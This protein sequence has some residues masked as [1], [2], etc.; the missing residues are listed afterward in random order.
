M[1]T[2]TNTTNGEFN[3]TLAQKLSTCNARLG[4]DQSVH[5]VISSW[6]G[7][8]ERWHMCQPMTGQREERQSVLTAEAKWARHELSSAPACQVQQSPS[9]LL[10]TSPWGDS[11]WRREWLGVLPAAGDSRNSPVRSVRDLN[12]SM[13][14]YE[15][16]LAGWI[17]KCAKS[18]S[19][20]AYRM[21]EYAFK[22]NLV[23]YMHVKN[24]T[25]WTKVRPKC[26]QHVFLPATSHS[27]TYIMIWELLPPS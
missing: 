25:N 19:M 21:M 10:P 20:H 3:H 11:S 2:H 5:T 17:K 14:F 13:R 4:L 9:H 12:W 8:G 1:Y 16:S 15:P 27:Q 23:I 6:D 24:Q 22:R 26:K 18:H 7:V